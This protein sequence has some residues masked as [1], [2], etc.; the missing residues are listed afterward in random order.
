MSHQQSF[1]K[2]ALPFKG[3]I[4]GGLSEGKSVT[5]MARVMPAATSFHVNLLCGSGGNVDI[6]LHFVARYEG[7]AAVVV[8]NTFNNSQWG[9]EEQ[10]GAM[11]FARGAEFTLTFLVTR[12]SYSVVVN[13]AHFLEYLHRLSASRVSTISVDGGLQVHS[14]SFQSP[15]GERRQNHS[16]SQQNRQKSNQWRK[17]AQVYPPVFGAMGISP[18]PP[19]Y[20]PQPSYAVPYKSIM[21]GGLHP[22]KTLTVQ[23]LVNHKANMW[24]LNLRFNSGIALHFNARFSENAVVLNSLLQEQW[25]QEERSGVMPFHRGHPFTVT[26]SCDAQC[27]KVFVNSIHTCNY[28]HRYSVLQDVDILEVS[29]DLSLTS[30]MV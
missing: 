18:A 6:A 7:H 17:A 26:I 22:G 29:G 20:S 24:S 10:N 16:R 1:F 25:G 4:Q 14:I 8:C 15:Q 9:Q 23:G 28:N 3:H 5:L 12:N 27:Y 30:V 21:P 19:A 2:P 11:P 13:G